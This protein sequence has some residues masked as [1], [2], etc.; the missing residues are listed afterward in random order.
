MNKDTTPKAV[1]ETTERKPKKKV[2][3]VMAGLL[4]VAAIIIGLLVHS[5]NKNRA[6][7]AFQIDH[8]YYSKKL[9][10]DMVN[11]ALQNQGK[12]TAKQKSQAAQNIF[13]LYKTEIAAKKSGITPNGGELQSAQSQMK[14]PPA[15]TSSGQGYISL[16]VYNIALLQAYNRYMEGNDQGYVFVFDFSQKIIPPPAQEKPI[17]GQGNQQLINQDKAYANQQAHKYFTEFKDNKI[18]ADKLLNTINS[19][20]R[21]NFV[22]ASTLISSSRGSIKG[23][24]LYSDIYSYVAAQSKPG[25]SN[26][27]VGKVE[28][29]LNPKP[30]D[31]AD[32]YYYFVQL[33]KASPVIDNPAAKV[34][35]QASKLEA[36]YYGI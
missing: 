23:Q 9:V 33:T 2:L 30:G 5:N 22:G 14:L 6:S 20:P 15:K 7:N 29:K 26:I 25:L 21:L 18:S 36:A 12:A 27:I 35:D 1:L 17:P 16:I 34:G 28:T 10:L 19:N 4:I 11:F 8:Q 31:Y 24:I 3:F 32:G 13:N